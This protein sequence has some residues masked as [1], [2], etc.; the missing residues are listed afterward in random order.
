VFLLF[1]GLFTGAVL[2]VFVF[3]RERWFPI[4]ITVSPA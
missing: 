2:M 1:A 4:A 3:M